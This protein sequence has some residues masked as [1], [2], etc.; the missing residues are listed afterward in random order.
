MAIRDLTRGNLSWFREALSRIQTEQQR[1]WGGLSPAGV[2][3]HLRY[4]V[5][6]SL[7][8]GPKVPDLSTPVLR[9]VFRWVFFDWFTDWPKGKIKAPKELTPDPQFDLETERQKLFDAMEQFLDELERSPDR[10]AVNAILGPLPLRYFSHVHGVHFRHH[11]RQYG[12][13][14]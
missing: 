12:V 1:R 6:C 11:M 8:N 7:E 13:D 9:V 5:E 4:G 14:V 3:A 2:M 10:K